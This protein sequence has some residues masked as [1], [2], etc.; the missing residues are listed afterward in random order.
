MTLDQVA[1][2]GAVGA[3]E[4]ALTHGAY[5]EAFLC[6]TDAL[7]PQTTDAVYEDMAEF[8]RQIG[9]RATPDVLAQQLVIKKHRAA[10]EISE[11]ERIAFTAFSTVLLGLD[12]FVARERERIERK[13]APKEKRRPV[14][15]DETTLETV[16]GPLDTWGG[17]GR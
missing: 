4:A 1:L 10:A 8:V 13:N 3:Y 15:I 14:P 2:C 6:G 16:D 7:D 11:P 12:R 9:E 17:K 5:L